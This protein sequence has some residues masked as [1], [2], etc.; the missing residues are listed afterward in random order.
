MKLTKKEAYFEGGTICYYDKGTGPAVIFLHGYLESS[1][2]WFDFIDEFPVRFRTLAVDLPGHGE[3]G[4]FSDEHTMEFMA[5]AVREVMDIE[6]IEKVL[7]AGHSMG[8]YVALAFLEKYPDRLHAYCLFH[9]HPF[10]D[11]EEIISNRNREIRVV[12]SGK[13]DVIYPVNV[14]KMFADFNINRFIRK[15][16]EHKKIASQISEAGIIAVL[17]GMIK[18]PSRAGLLEKGEV[19]LLMIMGRHDNYIPFKQ[20]KANIRLPQNS[21]LIVLENSGHLGFVEEKEKSSESIA[22]FFDRQINN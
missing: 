20:I 10:A 21:E 8:G 14:P 19:P 6:G 18:R 16:E 3:S 22:D 13:K 5:D 9:S 15:L 7:L 1:G 12:E 11:T 4:I 17:K 2:V